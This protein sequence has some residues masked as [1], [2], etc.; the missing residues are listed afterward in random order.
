MENKMQL[1][2]AYYYNAENEKDAELYVGKTGSN[3]E[4]IKYWK[5]AYD[6]K[7]SNSEIADIFA[8]EQETGIDG[9]DYEIFNKLIK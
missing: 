4:F 1:F 2:I 7:I 5:R 6:Q 3:K 9:K 8:V